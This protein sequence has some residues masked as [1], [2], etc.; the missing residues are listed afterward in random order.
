MIRPEIR[1]RIILNSWVNGPVQL[2]E[3]YFEHP[4][5][6]DTYGIKVLNG[7]I[8]EI[9]ILNKEVEIY[10]R[11]FPGDPV[12]RHLAAVLSF[13]DARELM[14]KLLPAIHLD[15]KIIPDTIPKQEKNFN[16][17]NYLPARIIAQPEVM[18]GNIDLEK[19][20]IPFPSG[21]E[22]LRLSLII[23]GVSPFSEEKV[24][25]LLLNKI[26]AINLYGQLQQVLIRPFFRGNKAVSIE[27]ELLSPKKLVR[28]ENNQFMPV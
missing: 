9:E 22:G 6:P 27:K 11:S 8:S 10:S 7:N 4:L 26:E 12:I 24:P 25:M 15:E 20:E 14:L 28:F 17:D 21:S 23:A 18:V 3:R 2:P 1:P 5:P 19:V 13:E 16:P